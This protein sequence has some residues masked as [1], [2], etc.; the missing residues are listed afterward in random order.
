[1]GRAQEQE[2]LLPNFGRPYEKPYGL[3]FCEKIYIDVRTCFVRDQKRER[4]KCVYYVG[5]I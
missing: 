4:K 5:Y 3:P 1:M 2:V